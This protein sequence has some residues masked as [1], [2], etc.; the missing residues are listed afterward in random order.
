MLPTFRRRAGKTLALIRGIRYGRGVQSRGRVRF[1]VADGSY[2]IG[3][4]VL[5]RGSQFAI[6][7]SA[8]SPAILS[9]GDGVTIGDRC[10]I[11][12]A[13]S[14]SIGDRSMI[15]WDCQILDTDF[16]PITYSDGSS[17][18]VSAPVTIGDHV[19]VGTGSIILKGVSIGDGAVIGAGSVVVGD[20]EPNWL[21]AGNPA[22][23][24][25]E[26]RSWH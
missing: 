10:V 5:G 13:C 1:V 2:S 18:A 22:R 15:S 26:V 21:A 17:P 14:V 24:I 12:V 8:G 9:I 7:G 11:N 23:P 3:R 4:S 25:R 20:I 16:H 19:L 6:I